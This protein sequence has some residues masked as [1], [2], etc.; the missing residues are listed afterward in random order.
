MKSI[1]GHMAED[2]IRSDEFCNLDIRGR[3]DLCFRC[4]MGHFKGAVCSLGLGL[5]RHFEQQGNIF[6]FC[7]SFFLFLMP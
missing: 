3:V 5:E 7:F 4:L 2:G 6:V 1:K